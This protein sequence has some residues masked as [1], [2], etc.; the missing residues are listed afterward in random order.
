MSMKKT[1]LARNLANK[2]EGRMKAAGVPKRFAGG[3]GEAAAQRKAPAADAK[4]KLVPVACRLPADL[5]NRLRD[6]AVGREGG[7]NAVLAE[8]VERWLES[9]SRR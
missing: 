1:D 4:A 6:R 8:A 7:I 5:V 3:S 9:E 2:L